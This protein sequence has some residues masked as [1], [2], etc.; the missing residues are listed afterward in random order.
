MARRGI[1]RLIVSDNGR[2]FKGRKLKRFNAAKGIRWRFNL[3]KAPWWGGMFERMI[4]AT[5]RCLKRAIGSRRLT[6]EQLYTVLTEIEAVIN[7][8]HITFLYV[9]DVEEPL[10]PSHLLCGRRLL[11]SDDSTVPLANE[12]EFTRTSMI[13]DIQKIEVLLII[14][15]KYGTKNI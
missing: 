10:T 9:D 3:A 11:G 4:R 1:P 2:T 13:E 5:K 12:N 8:R 7:S 15:G 6:Y 14:F